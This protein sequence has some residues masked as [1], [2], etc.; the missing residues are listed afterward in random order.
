MDAIDR[1]AEIFYQLKMDETAQRNGVLLYIAV[2]DHQ[3]AVFGDEGIHKMVGEQYWFA[4]VSKMLEQFR[5]EHLVDGI[6]ECINDIGEALYQ[7]FP[8][9]RET[10]KNELPD[11]IV[12]GR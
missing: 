7:H 1:A 8:Y 4:E 2:R 9:N 6:V 5:Q 11:E 3:V 10:D 12:F